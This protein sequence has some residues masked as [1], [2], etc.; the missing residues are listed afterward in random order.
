MTYCD[1][2]ELSCYI[3]DVGFRNRFIAEAQKRFVLDTPLVT[4]DYILFRG[5]AF[6]ISRLKLFYDG[7]VFCWRNYK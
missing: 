1:M 4:G 2:E 6:E 3:G 5:A 7:L